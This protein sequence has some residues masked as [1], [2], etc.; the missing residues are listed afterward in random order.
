MA[1]ID[2]GVST[3][4]G[5]SRCLRSAIYRGQLRHRRFSPK[6]HDFT[7]DVFMMYLD[8]EELDRVFSDTF[9]WSAQSIA[10]GRFSPK[11]FFFKN[12]QP[13][14]PQVR[15]YVYEQSGIEVT[16]SVRMLANLR[17]FGHIFNPLV[18]YYCF[19]KQENLLAIVAEVTNTPW[20]EKH[21]YVLPCD[22]NDVHQTIRFEKAFHVSPFQPMDTYYVWQ[23]TKPDSELG[24]HMQ[25]FMISG[26]GQLKENYQQVESEQLVKNGEDINEQCFFDATLRLERIEVTPKVL[27]R[28]L[29][30]YPLMTVKVV[31]AIYWQAVK[32]AIKKIPFYS[33]P[34]SADSEC[35]VK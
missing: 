20:K 16:G 32:L 7:Y 10:L 27:D 31:A 22:P 12:Q 29:M 23:S 13:L 30:V 1:N 3:S 19:D 35:G 34:G 6:Q 5:D 25:S 15:Q 2:C 28:T 4:G 11:D 14:A 21:I 24:I 17:Y 8:L 18:C 9:F 26:A 33:H